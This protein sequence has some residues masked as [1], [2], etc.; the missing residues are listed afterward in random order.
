MKMQSCIPLSLCPDFTTMWSQRC[1]LSAVASTESIY[2]P[3]SCL[4]KWFHCHL[5][6]YLAQRCQLSCKWRTVRQERMLWYSL[7]VWECA[8]GRMS[9]HLFTW[10]WWLNICWMQSFGSTFL[11]VLSVCTYVCL[12]LNVLLYA[13]MKDSQF[14]KPVWEFPF[15][16]FN[17]F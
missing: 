7:C 12:H 11:Y 4:K 9:F 2:S 5:I 1:I 16:L 3:Q 10:V 6:H 14:N 8:C 13:F 17:K 15:G